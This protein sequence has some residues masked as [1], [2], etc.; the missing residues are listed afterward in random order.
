MR[1]AQSP[2]ERQ[3]PAALRR[4]LWLAPTEPVPWDFSQQPSH[5]LNMAER[6]QFAI[7]KL[8]THL[9]YWWAERRLRLPVPAH[10]RKTL[11]EDLQIRPQLRYGSNFSFVCSLSPLVCA[12]DDRAFPLPAS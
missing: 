9:Q 4:K 2:A 10:G 1:L 11:A 7:C 12:T 3:H 6:R 8:T 5:P